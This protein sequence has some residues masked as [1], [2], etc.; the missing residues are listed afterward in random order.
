VTL[1]V[2]G[3]PATV[4]SY[5]FAIGGDITAVDTIATARRSLDEIPGELLV[6]I[7]AEA[8]LTPALDLAA[9]L[10]L[11]RPHVGVVLLRHRVDVGVLNQALRAG[12]REVV[13]PDDLG[14][15]TDACRRSVEISRRISG[16]LAGGIEPRREGKLVTVFAAKGGCGK[17]T[18]ATNLAVTV[19]RSGYHA[20]LVD[21]DL[22][23]GD[24]AIALQLMPSST[25]VDAVQLGTIDEQAIRALVTRHESGLDT[26]LAPLEPG[27]A[28]RIDVG[29]VQQLLRVLRAMYDVVVI[30]TPPAFSEHVLTAFDQSD[31][32]VLLTTLDVPALKNLR[33]TLDMLDLLG[34]P[35]SAWHVV[36]NRADSKVG[37]SLEEVEKTLDVPIAAQV[38]S[39]RAV[40]ASINRGVPLVLDEPDHPVS[41]SITR[42]ARQ[43]ASAVDAPTANRGSNTGASTRP[44]RRRFSLTRRGGQG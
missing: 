25:I 17:T 7:G 4:E 13:K 18:M 36:L 27:E 39:S 24:V 9:A 43:V 44:A 42:L 32:Y 30:D 5:R 1:L 3:D 21:L 20:C 23:F 15:L 22:A 28:E 14:A 12:V 41:E 26:L 33:I 6:V 19:A 8:D 2:E 31:A 38:P 10:H 11:E 37:L 40:S 16:T 34:Y 29:T 35:Q